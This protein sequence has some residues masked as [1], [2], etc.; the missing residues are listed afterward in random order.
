MMMMIGTTHRLALPAA[1]PPAPHP[2]FTLTHRRY[3]QIV[4]WHLLYGFLYLILFGSPHHNNNNNNNKNGKGAGAGGYGKGSSSYS[5]SQLRQPPPQQRHHVLNTTTTHPTS[6]NNNSNSTDDDEQMIRTMV[7]RLWN[8]WLQEQQQQ[9]QHSQQ[10]YLESVL[11]LPDFLK[12]YYYNNFNDYDDY[13]DEPEED[14]KHP[15]HHHHHHQHKNETTNTTSTRPKGPN[16]RQPPQPQ[17]QPQP[18]QRCALILYGLPRAFRHRVLPSLIRHVL[19]PNARYNCHVFAYY[20]A[21]TREGS[22]RS[23][24][25]G[26]LQ[27]HDLQQLLPL[28]VQAVQDEYYGTLHKVLEQQQQ[29]R[30]TVVRIESYTNEQFLQERGAF[31]NKTHTT[32]DGVEDDNNNDDNNNIINS[33]NNKHNQLRTNKYNNNKYTKSRHHQSPPPHRRPLYIPWRAGFDQDTSDNIVRM[34]HGIQGA[35]NLMQQYQQQQDQQQQQQQSVSYH[36]VAF[37]RADVFYMTPVDIWQKP[38]VSYPARLYHAPPLDWFKWPK[39]RPY[40]DQNANHN[41]KYNHNKQ[42]DVHNRIAVIPAFSPVNDRGMYGPYQALQLW[43]TQRFAW[44][45]E[46]VRSQRAGVGYGI[47]DERFLKYT[48]LPRLEQVTLSSTTTPQ[49]GSLLQ[50]AKQARSWPFSSSSSSSSSLSLLS[51]PSWSYWTALEA[52]LWPLHQE[53]QMKLEVQ[54]DPT[55][56]FVRA[57]SDQSLWI[58]DC[59]TSNHDLVQANLHQVQEILVQQTMSSSSTSSSL[60]CTVEPLQDNKTQNVLQA[61]CRDD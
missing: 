52:F 36:R 30:S 57:R 34:W 2:R 26:A 21:L 43:A 12:P 31:L 47:H 38:S 61:T 8:L 1:P 11:E 18:Q 17:L 48:L 13:Q 51:S 15:Y 4:V 5:A 50:E 23:G 44:I 9:G 41:N 16:E 37:L 53:Q 42:Y 7:H 3:L 29:R 40:Q 22:G 54:I 28:A 45:E 24:S 20:H 58:N 14:D 10:Q 33:N 39:T 55:W 59:G 32:L 19:I 60:S 27:P 6:T 25:G 49:I 46:H 56:C 35:W